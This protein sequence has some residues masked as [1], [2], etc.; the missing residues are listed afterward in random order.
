MEIRLHPKHG[1][2]PS[3]SKCFYCGGDKEVLL[4]GASYKKEAPRE[5]VWDK[6]PCDKCKEHMEKGCMLV[7][8]RD[9]EGKKNPKDPYRTG[10]LW[11]I[12]KEAASRMFGKETPF[13]W[14]EES[15]AKEIGL[16]ETVEKEEVSVDG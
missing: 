14:I 3:V 11:V 10:R 15:T 6:T 13:A 4:L 16:H 7:E 8:V 9:G 2:N 5:A 1:L 12:T